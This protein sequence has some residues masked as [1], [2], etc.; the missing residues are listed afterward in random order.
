M[1]SSSLYVRRLLE[2]AKDH[3]FCRT[4]GR[5]ADVRDQPTLQDVVL[6]RQTGSRKPAE[7][8]P[9][10]RPSP[11]ISTRAHPSE[12]ETTNTVCPNGKP[13]MISNCVPGPSR[14]RNPPR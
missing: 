12:I 8:N 13:P 9:S 6:R 5:D 3:E 4:N 10:I 11:S 1:V 7:A 14:R 2:D